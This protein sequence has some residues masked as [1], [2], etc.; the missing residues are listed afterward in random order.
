MVARVD[1][2][3]RDAT[4]ASVIYRGEAMRKAETLRLAKRS[5]RST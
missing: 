3:G 1:D 4:E 5:V 2:E